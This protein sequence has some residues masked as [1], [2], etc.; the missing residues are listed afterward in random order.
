LSRYVRATLGRMCSKLDFFLPG[1]RDQPHLWMS[2]QPGPSAALPPTQGS[3]NIRRVYQLF[4]HRQDYMKIF[5][6]T[7]LWISPPFVEIAAR[8]NLRTGCPQ[9]RTDCQ[10]RKQTDTPHFPLGHASQASCNECACRLSAKLTRFS[11]QE[12]ATFH[13]GFHAENG[14]DD[15]RNEPPVYSGSLGW[16]LNY[17]G[18][19]RDKE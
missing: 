18:F 13:P 8:S 7:H 15:V 5:N 12:V 9:F 16:L 11:L 4:P 10:R 1:I 17:R 3:T 6:R 2:R 14:R 19:R